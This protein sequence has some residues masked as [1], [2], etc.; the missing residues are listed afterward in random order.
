[1]LGFNF[2]KNTQT[3]GW[4]RNLL[5]RKAWWHN[6]D[7]IYLFNYCLF[8][9][10]I[11]DRGTRDPS[12]TNKNLPDHPWLIIILTKNFKLHQLALKFAR[13][14]AGIFMTKF[15]CSVQ[16]LNRYL[17]FEHQSC[18]LELWHIW[19]WRH[20]VDTFP[21]LLARCAGNSPVTGEF[22]PQRLLTRSL[23][24]S[25]DLRLNKR[26]CKHS[27]CR[28]SETPSRS[29]YRHCNVMFITVARVSECICSFQCSVNFGAYI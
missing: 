7:V 4:S 27:I 13:A 10:V 12:L 20:Q 18:E 22:P 8:S 15:S 23:D 28:W 29:L 21:A 9:S 17:D 6:Y 14:Y 24:A 3:I 5:K 25:F 16:I 1:M 11:F 19:W 26:L 2:E